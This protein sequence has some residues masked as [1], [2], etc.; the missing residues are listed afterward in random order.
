MT[1]QITPDALGFS[2]YQQAATWTSAV[3]ATD[4][5]IVYPAL[6]LANE[7]PDGASRCRFRSGVNVERP[8]RPRE[9]NYL[10]ALQP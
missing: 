2:A 7:G 1:G 3:V 5:P 9:Q 4:H 10:P 6:G 8:Q